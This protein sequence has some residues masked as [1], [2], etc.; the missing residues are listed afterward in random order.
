LFVELVEYT[1]FIGL[2]ELIY[3]VKN[4]ANC[5]LLK[6]PLA[7]G[8]HTSI[9]KLYSTR[10]IQASRTLHD[11]IYFGEI[12][13]KDVWHNNIQLRMGVLGCAYL[14][15]SI[16]NCVS[17]KTQILSERLTRVYLP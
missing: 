14:G 15:K 5:V 7:S 13:E 3:F 16:Y 9:G 10:V 6:L 12:S 4:L 11:V 17:T 8:K 2:N 1:Q